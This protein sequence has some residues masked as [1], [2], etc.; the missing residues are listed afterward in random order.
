MRATRT[1]VT[2]AAAVLL[3]LGVAVEPALGAGT[4]ATTRAQAAGEGAV[5][6]GWRQ[7]S[8]G[9]AHTCA[10]SESRRLYCWGS[11]AAGQLGDG[12]DNSDQS[13]PVEVVGGRTDWGSVSAGGV[14]TCARTTVGQLFCW[15]SDFYGQLGNGG[16]NTDVGEPTEVGGGHRVW[17]VVSVGM[18]HTCARSRAGRLFCWGR[19][20]SGQ[21]GDDENLVNQGLPTEVAGGGTDWSQVSAGMFHTCALK[22][23]GHLYCFGADG[24][25]QLGDGDPL[26]D[27]HTPVEVSSGA[28]NWVQVATGASHTCALKSVGRLYCWG[29][30]VHGQRGDGD[31]A[32]DDLAAAPVRV[33]E[34]TTRWQGVAA[35]GWH[36]CARTTGLRGGTVYCWGLDDDGEVGDGE[37]RANQPAP[38]AI[39]GGGKYRQLSAGLYHNCA[40]RVTDRLFCWGDGGA[41]RIGN[42]EPGVDQPAPVRI[43]VPV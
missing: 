26:V 5:T 12:G 9:A 4:T 23:T 17:K 31:P 6:E 42:G 32:T 40:I 7:V 20:G 2:V 15:G 29:W 33:A 11:D 30:D 28:T 36:T 35:S 8:V 10:I 27:Q 22:T 43:D 13:T 34:G 25:G 1:F 14:S 24:A 16:D 18:E 41:G 38:V 21:L 3:L 39:S 19:D 37:P